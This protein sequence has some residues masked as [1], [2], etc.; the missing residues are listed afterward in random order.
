MMNE[1]I[2]LLV[3]FLF[4]VS[5][6][7]L[8]PDIIM[9]LLLLAWS[10]IVVGEFVGEAIARWRSKPIELSRCGNPNADAIN[11][12]RTRLISEFL[13][14]AQAVKW[15]RELMHKLVSDCETKAAKWLEWTQIG[16]RLG[17]ILGLVGTL[18][19]MGPALQ[20]L[21]AGDVMQIAY[22]IRIAFSTTVVGLLVGAV[23]YT[24]TT[25]RRRWYAHDLN[26]VEFLA[27]L[28]A[29]G[30]HGA[31]AKAAKASGD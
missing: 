17:P 9:L 11:I 5:N 30:E 4:A 16:V 10:I 27:E 15:R 12:R 20:G 1:S 22:N 6:A 18:I 8:V 7:L 19:P 31:G 23:C 29:G 21:A 26:D 14:G 13:N 3:R 24:V 28:L 25:V 2:S